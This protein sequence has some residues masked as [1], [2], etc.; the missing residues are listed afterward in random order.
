MQLLKALLGGNDISSNL[1]SGQLE[2]FLTLLQTCDSM[3]LKTELPRISNETIDYIR[4]LNEISAELGD[5]AYM[6]NWHNGTEECED[7]FTKTYTEDGICYTFNGFN[8]TDLYREYTVQYQQSLE[9]S[10]N[11][12]STGRINRTLSWSLENG[13]PENEPLTTYPVRVTSASTRGAS[14]Q[15]LLM[16]EKASI[17]Y[18]CSGST[19]GYKIVVH[20]PDDVPLLSKNFVR[21]S[22]TKEVTIAVQPVMV[23]TSDGISKYPVEKR[24]CFMNGERNLKFFKVYSEKNCEMECFTNYTLRVCGCVKFSMPRTPDMPV[25]AEDKILCYLQAED[26]MLIDMFNDRDS[27]NNEDCNCLPSC[28][29]LEYDMEISQGNYDMNK[30]LENEV[31]GFEDLPSYLI[32]HFKDKQFIPSKR[33]ELYGFTDFLANCGGVLGLF[34]GFSILSIIEWLYHFTLRLWSNMQRKRNLE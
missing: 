2:E 23:T 6:C 12:S 22:P 14:L 34:T 33:S 13:Y 24:K 1:T 8:G 9:Q 31:E 27:N 30:I 10:L 7:L 18:G 16:I 3:L 5:Q 26:N 4:I 21:V 19:A 20:T 28:T 15:V 29:A 25:C 17:D 11:V 32:V